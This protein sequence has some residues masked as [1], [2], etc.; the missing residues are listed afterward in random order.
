MARRALE[1]GMNRGDGLNLLGLAL[2][3]LGKFDEADTLYREAQQNDPRN[4]TVILNRANILVDKL[5]FFEAWPMFAAARAIKDEPVFRRDEG[6]ARILSGDYERGWP[7]YEARLAMPNALRVKPACPLW[8]G[9]NLAGKKLLIVAEQGF[10]DVIQFA[11]Y[12]EF[13]HEAELTWVIPKPLIRLMT[14][15]VRGK[16]VSEGDALLATDFYVPMMSLPY[17]TGAPASR[18]HAAKT[19]SAGNTEA[20]QSRQA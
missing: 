9:A 4:A 6:M 20:T 11:R 7:L 15:A 8:D 17:L 18:K 13:I 3:E 5:Q 16:I 1:N 14:S 12:Q 10:G 2:A 19:A